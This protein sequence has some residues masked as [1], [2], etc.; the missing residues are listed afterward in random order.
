MEA[1]H[2]SNASQLK[3]LIQLHGW[4]DEENVGQDGAE[5]AWF[6]VQHAIGD[7]GFQQSCLL[8]LRSSAA[9]GRVPLRHVAYLEDRIAMYQ[10]LP[11]RY[12][13]QW[14]DDPT[15]GRTRPWTL[16]DPERVNQLRAE[17]GL[18][19]LPPIPGRGPDLPSQQRQDLEETHRWW[20]EWL[21]SKGWRS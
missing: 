13:T 2:V 14:L 19:P 21:V 4:P 7:P 11:Q 10:G 16:A 18:D 12:G 15:D 20:Q 6:I 5:A 8:L 1:V 17:A 9:A 3:G